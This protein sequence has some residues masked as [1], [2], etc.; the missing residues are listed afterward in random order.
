[1]P[2]RGLP[3]CCAT[4]RSCRE[5]LPSDVSIPKLLRRSH[6]RLVRFADVFAADISRFGPTAEYERAGVTPVESTPKEIRDL[7][8][9]M[10]DVLDGKAQRSPEDEARER[11]FR[12]LLCPTH[13]SYHARSRIGAAFL[14]DHADLL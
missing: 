6:G 5:P 9:E 12:N 10:L 1:M 7:A 3:R 14:R 13:Y 11:A 8:M 4:A 2:A